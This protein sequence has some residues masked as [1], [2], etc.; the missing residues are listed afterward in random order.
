MS[1]N[2]D[3]PQDDQLDDQQPVDDQP[4]DEAVEDAQDLE[5]DN[6]KKGAAA[7]VI[8]AAVHG[9]L[10][11]VAAFAVFGA[12]KILEQDA[13]PTRVNTI[14][15][16]AKEKDKPKEKRELE[17]KVELDAPTEADVPSPTN[18][19]DVPTEVAE[20]EAESDATTPK[21]REEAV[22][23]SEA[24]GSGAFMAIGAGGGSAGMFGSRSGGGRKRAVGKGGGSKG[25]EG[26]VEASLRWFKRHQSPGG[27]WEADKYYQNCTEGA[28]CEP[29]KLAEG[30]TNVAMTGYA[31]LCFLGAGYDHKTP[32]KYKAVVKKGVDWLVSQQKNDGLI[33]SRNYEHPIAVMALAEAYAMTADPELRGP[34]QK[35][36]DIVLAR[37]NQD[38][39]KG[40]EGYIGGLGWDYVKPTA[41][42]DSSVTGWN[43]MALKSALAGGLNVG[44]GM[45]GS[46]EWLERHWKAS[47]SAKV[48]DWKEWK[49][50][51]AYDKSRFAYC[52]NTGEPGVEEKSGT[53]R[54]SIGLV[55]GIFL[56]HLNG[57]PMVESLANTVMEKQMP[58]T[59]PTNTYY[60]YYNTMAIFQMGGDRW[61]K[62]NGT[63]RDMLVGAQAKTNDCFDGSWDPANSG[64][65]AMSRVLSTAYCTLCLEVYYRYAQV[66]DLHK[67]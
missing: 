38:K 55:C 25:S 39:E 63:V 56:G 23:D 53:G 41:R 67:K 49:D 54:E 7:W 8:S 26:A 29:G 61:T 50:I 22:A 6:K 36:I 10:I 15:P 19:L 2:D 27:N 3:Q 9:V 42:N 34:S 12:P 62:W 13:P 65:S 18:T 1:A 5:T 16:P 52:W 47:N 60:M 20:R 28:K 43:V 17:A 66:K 40:P 44:K 4:V 30:D 31:V 11:T 24:G 58:R 48:G 32:N 37:Q 59:Y 21:G 64:V 45:D 33:G 14:D 57:D 46:K 51:T 35:G